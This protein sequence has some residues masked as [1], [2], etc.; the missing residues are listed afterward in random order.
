MEHSEFESLLTLSTQIERLLTIAY[1][2]GTRTQPFL[3]FGPPSKIGLLPFFHQECLDQTSKE[4]G[5]ECKDELGRKIGQGIEETSYFSFF[6]FSS[7]SGHQALSLNSHG[8][9]VEM[10]LKCVNVGGVWPSKYM[11]VG[12]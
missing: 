10:E 9:K 12:Y 5:D 6:H 4:G 2:T 7:P 8:L 1:Y 11:W 3:T